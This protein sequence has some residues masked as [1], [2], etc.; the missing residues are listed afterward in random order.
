[1]HLPNV[2]TAAKAP[3]H[4]HGICSGGRRMHAE[5][6]VCHGRDPV[7]LI[8]SADRR[9]LNAI[10]PAVCMTRL[11]PQATPDT[12]VKEECHTLI[13][14]LHHHKLNPLIRKKNKHLPVQTPWDAL[15]GC[16]MRLA[17]WRSFRRKILPSI[18]DDAYYAPTTH[19]IKSRD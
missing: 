1:M 7:T 12:R 8:L 10:E 5:A 4:A 16:T 13:N 9:R 14:T 18:M 6:T 11:T 17:P 19:V 3:R 2:I 15:S